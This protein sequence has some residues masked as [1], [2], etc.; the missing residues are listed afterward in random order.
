MRVY[1]DEEFHQYLDT[2]TGE[3]LESVSRLIRMLGIPKSYEKGGSPP[4]KDILTFAA[5]R[6]IALE[7]ILH[8]LIQGRP[9]S[10]EIPQLEQ[11]GKT[12]R[13]SVGEFLPGIQRWLADES[14]EYVAH[15]EVVYDIEAGVAGTFD[16]MTPRHLI[17]V[18]CT[19][20]EEKEHWQIQL[21]AY[22]SMD[23]RPV[24]FAPA[25]LHINKKFKKGYIFRVY[26]RKECLDKWSYARQAWI[27][28]KRG[29]ETAR[30]K[31][32]GVAA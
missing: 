18:K 23:D 17:D 27:D 29:F 7:S 14:P 26:D 22:L 25:I 8:A 16:L 12:L 24:E 11:N 5:E 1:L 28:A 30:E 3:K 21:G 6:G 32:Q 31:I 15:Q 9:A 4:P 19:S 2:E 20:A 13:E 10:V